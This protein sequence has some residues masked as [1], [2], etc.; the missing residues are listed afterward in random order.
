MGILTRKHGEEFVISSDHGAPTA[1]SARAPRRM[2]DIY[3]VWT[4]SEWSANIDDAVRFGSLDDA[5]D[6]VRV[7]YQKLNA[8]QVK[9]AR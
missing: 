8:Y 9:Q 5:D 1:S 4:G 3:Q 6:Y 7:N 2:N